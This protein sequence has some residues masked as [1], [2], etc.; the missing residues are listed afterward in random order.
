MQQVL[1]RI[2]LPHAYGAP[3]GRVNDSTHF[4]GWSQCICSP[5]ICLCV[6]KTDIIYYKSYANYKSYASFTALQYRHQGACCHKNLVVS[7]TIHCI[8]SQLTS[9]HCTKSG[10]GQSNDFGMASRVHVTTDTQMVSNNHGLNYK[11]RWVCRRDAIPK[12]W[13]PNQRHSLS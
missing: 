9:Y 8:A 2:S 1:A 5:Y 3:G 6:C 10:F 4:C 11:K 12:F 7:A 13:R